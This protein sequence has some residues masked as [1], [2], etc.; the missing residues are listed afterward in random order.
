MRSGDAIQ[1]HRCI[2]VAPTPQRHGTT[3]LG[4]RGFDGGAGSEQWKPLW[5]C[6]VE[7]RMKLLQSPVAI[8]EFGHVR[9]RERLLPR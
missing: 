1:R 6:I 5:R 4:P 9:S 7:R 8:H 3:Q 2:R